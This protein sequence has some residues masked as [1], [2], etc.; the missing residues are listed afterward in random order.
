MQ[1]GKRAQP[2]TRRSRGSSRPLGSAGSQSFPRSA[3]CPGGLLSPWAA[4]R[5]GER[6][7]EAGKED[8]RSCLAAGGRDPGKPGGEDI[9]Y[10]STGV[11]GKG[12]SYSP[13]CAGKGR[14][15]WEGAGRPLLAAAGSG[16]GPARPVPP[17]W[18]RQ[19]WTG[20]FTS[21]G[22]PVRAVAARVQVCEVFR[23]LLVKDVE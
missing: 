16:A 17:L 21:L 23:K 9:F 4:E 19:S 3:S 6:R 5:L 14:E 1:T 8:V 20:P 12:G 7:G 18:G 22:F 11:K 10:F 15:G 2:D 13:P